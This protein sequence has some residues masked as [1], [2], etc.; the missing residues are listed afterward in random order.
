MYIH[1]TFKSACLILIELEKSSVNCFQLLGTKMNST[2]SEN[3]LSFLTFEK[4][5][6]FA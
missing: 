6:W 1:K 3:M 4:L 2:L 5:A